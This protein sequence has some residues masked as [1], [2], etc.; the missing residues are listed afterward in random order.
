MRHTRG[1]DPRL[2]PQCAIQMGNLQ[3]E[4]YKGVFPKLQEL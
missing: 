3:R 2:G 4:S 1:G